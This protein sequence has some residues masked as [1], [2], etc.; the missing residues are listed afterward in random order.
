MLKIILIIL[1]V[2]LVLAA[3]M[4]FFMMNGMNKLRK[5]KI[6]DIDMSQ[7]ADGD[8]TG[9]CNI[10]R[11]AVTLKVTVK[12]HQIV[13]VQE[14]KKMLTDLPEINQKIIEELKDKQSLQLDAV[15]GASVNT[16]AYLKAVE[17][18][19]EKGLSQ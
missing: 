11:W 7:V 5:M 9:S 12:N 3:V 18:A 10:G 19:L 8:Y 2:V 16:K 14:V 1:G 4:F 17:N 13:D 15:S 6:K